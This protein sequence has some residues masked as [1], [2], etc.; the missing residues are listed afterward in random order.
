MKL[1]A[2]SNLG[3]SQFMEEKNK[4]HKIMEIRKAIPNDIEPIETLW[5]EMM[6]FHVEYDD[7]FKMNNQALNKYHEYLTKNFKDKKKVI[8]V[9]IIN[10]T[11]VG[12]ISAS[13]LDYPPIYLFRKYIM[14]GEICVSR[15]NRRKGIGEQLLKELYKYAKNKKIKRIECLVA[16]K[17]PVSQNFWKKNSFRPYVHNMVKEI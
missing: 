4:I 3:F 9:A 1:I 2:I 8:F 17:N 15:N 16:L 13:I 11:I 5:K 6:D 14:V 10:K 7:Y 12:Y